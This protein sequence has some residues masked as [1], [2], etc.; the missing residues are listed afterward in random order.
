MR[1]KILTI[2]IEETDWYKKT[3]KAMT[4]HDY[5]RVYRETRGYTQKEL[6]SMLGGLSRQR[7]SDME[8]RRRPIN[9]DIAGQ[10]NQL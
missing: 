10:T 1:N 2:E 5:M 6:G 9:K 4:A 3:K 8:N 7:I